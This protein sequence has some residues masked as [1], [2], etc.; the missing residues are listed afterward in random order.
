MRADQDGGA[1]ARKVD[2]ESGALVW[3]ALDLD[4][5]AGLGNDRKHSRKSQAGS[6]A[7]DLRGEERL[8]DSS[9]RLV[10]HPCSRVGDAYPEEAAGTRILVG[11]FC[12][13]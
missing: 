2:V 3:S 12:T 13:D 7:R 11:R 1:H 5:P 9:L 6:F 8:E 10:V 4:L